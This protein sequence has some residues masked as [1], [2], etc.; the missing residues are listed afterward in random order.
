MGVWSYL[1]YY[2][3]CSEWSYSA[4]KGPFYPSNM[5]NSSDW[6]RYYYASVFDYLEIDSSFYRT[7]KAFTVKN[8][9]KRT[10][11]EE[12][13]RKNANLAIVSANNHYAG[14]GPG[15]AN[16]FRKMMGLSEV[17]W[18]EGKNQKEGDEGKSDLRR[19]SSSDVRQDHSMQRTLSDFYGI[20][21]LANTISFIACTGSVRVCNGT[22][23]S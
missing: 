9:F 23:K 12:R 11:K 2:L 14:F 6:P 5:D 22:S 13:R 10:L 7:P 4:W 8:W 1:Q 3:G 17:A 15:P 20:K 16:L 21:L 19:S 18:G